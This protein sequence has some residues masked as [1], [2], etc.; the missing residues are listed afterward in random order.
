MLSTSPEALQSHRKPQTLAKSLSFPV[1]S[2]WLVRREAFSCPISNI[3]GLRV[4]EPSS[5]SHAALASLANQC[6]AGANLFPGHGIFRISGASGFTGGEDRANTASHRPGL[7]QG[8][9][10]HLRVATGSSRI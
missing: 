8:M 9:Y 6:S 2:T 10:F 5:P 4:R 3:R 7:G 1:P